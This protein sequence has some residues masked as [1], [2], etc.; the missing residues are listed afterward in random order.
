LIAAALAVA[1]GLF[2]ILSAFLGVTALADWTM[3]GAE[4]CFVVAV[5]VFLGWFVVGCIDEIRNA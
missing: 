3:L 4:I 1:G 5:T 2:L